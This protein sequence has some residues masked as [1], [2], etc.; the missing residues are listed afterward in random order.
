[1]G[2]SFQ[3][4]GEGVPVAETLPGVLMDSVTLPA[5][6]WLDAIIDETKKAAVGVDTGEGFRRTVTLSSSAPMEQPDRIDARSKRRNKDL[7]IDH[8]ALMFTSEH[9]ADIENLAY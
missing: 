6:S 4:S 5:G 7:F 9:T 3:N 2:K 1:M 8:P